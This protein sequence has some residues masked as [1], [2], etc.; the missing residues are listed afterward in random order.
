MPFYCAPRGAQN[1]AIWGHANIT[2]SNGAFT[3]H[4]DFAVLAGIVR[5]LSWFPC[6]FTFLLFNDAISIDSIRVA[7][8]MG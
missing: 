4:I 5:I 2:V 8:M 6:N 1:T 3:W 7:S